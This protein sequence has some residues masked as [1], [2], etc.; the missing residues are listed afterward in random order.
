MKAMVNLADIL[1]A[2]ILVVD[3]NKT[4]VS[5]I[6][7]ML[8]GVGY[9]SVESTTDPNEVCELYRQNRYGVIV[10]DL[11]MPGMDGF[12][13]ME[14]LKE[15]EGDGY[16]PVLVTTAEPGHKLRALKAG[17]KDFIS[18]PFE[19]AELLARVHN[20]LEVRLLHLEARNYSRVLAETVRDLERSNTD[21]ERFAFVA[22]HDLQEPLRMV[23]SFSQLL[24]RRY[25][26]QMDERADECLE[27]I[28]TG[29]KRMA[30]L[31]EDLLSYSQIVHSREEGVPVDCNFVLDKVLDSC[32]VIIEED[33]AIVTRDP[34]PT[35]EGD[36]GQILQLFHNLLT[37][38]LKY[39]KRGGA[40]E[41]HVSARHAVNEWL[42][43]FQDNGI[44]IAREHL[45]QIFVIFK[46]L[47]KKTE[48]PGTGIG[49]ALC[50]RI[51]EGRSGRIWVESEPG[52]G[53]TFYF[54]WPDPREA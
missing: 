14:G 25:K 17:A 8:R 28:Q 46:R 35:V 16:L 41:V 54:T 47:H 9:I 51:I 22:S 53:S 27:Y 18:K 26:G 29:T 6:E 10:L 3:D 44:G 23:T 37:N 1:N 5:L 2:R 20:I 34:L 13:V 40:P 33:G 50:Q 48:Y 38:A 52:I 30:A 12:Q 36:E 15:I 19:M 42:F 21:L 7:R 49:L 32:R 39:R 31:I 45:E 24:A 11:Q 43:S 4:D